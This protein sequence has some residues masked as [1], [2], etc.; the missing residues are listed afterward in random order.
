MAAWGARRRRGRGSIRCSPKFPRPQRGAV[1]K[2]EIRGARLARGAT[3]ERSRARATSLRGAAGAATVGRRG[4]RHGRR[5]TLEQAGKAAGPGAG[6]REQ[7]RG[8]AW[9]AR[10][11]C[12]ARSPRFGT[13]AGGRKLRT[14]GLF[15]CDRTDQVPFIR[16]P[17]DP[18][19]LNPHQ[20]AKDVDVPGRAS[21]A[22]ADEMSGAR[23]R[24]TRFIP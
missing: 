15:H 9:A 10:E 8:P 12:G 4:F 14:P 22:P 7:G 18:L 3:F 5:P 1:P 20:L 16:S 17:S 23:C 21:G 11:P 19:V 6:C 2:R 24:R 13:G